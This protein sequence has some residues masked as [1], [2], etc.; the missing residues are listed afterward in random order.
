MLS[1]GL[2]VL[3]VIFGALMAGHG[4]QKLFGW[5]GG[6]GV[7]GTAGWLESMGMKPG[8]PWALLAGG[9]EFGGGVLTA[10]GF[11]N[12]LGPLASIGAMG[13]AA[14]KVH[15]G[16]PIWVTSGG[17]EL[18]L[19]NMAIALAIGVAGPGKFST[20]CA[21]G[22]KLPRRLVLVPGLA[23][24]AASIAYGVITSNQAMQQAAQ[25]AEQAQAPA[26]VE[27]EQPQAVRVPENAGVREVEERGDLA[28][29]EPERASGAMLQAG[30]D[31]A[32]AV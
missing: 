7:K 26:E 22:I 5:F 13:M 1:F 32:H 9:S 31:P 3:R 28:A 14:V 12:P 15:S 23:V 16:K 27:E 2:L 29:Q 6:H 4:A 18:P 19:T 8:K 30:Q 24:A 20:D 11:L 17:A 21:L 10:L 25:Q